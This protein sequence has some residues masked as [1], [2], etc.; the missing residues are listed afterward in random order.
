MFRIFVAGLFAIA[1]VGLTPH[2]HAQNN[3]G[4]EALPPLSEQHLKLARQVFIASKTGRSYD[5][6]LPN[7]AE[8]AKST[9]VR[10][11]PQIQ[12]GVLDAV[13]RVALKM[14]PM[15][16]ELDDGLIRVWARA[17]SEEELTDLL[18]FFESP[19]GQ[20]FS[21]NYSKVIST[22]L[23]LAENWT[24]KIGQ[25]MARRTKRELE[26]MVLQDAQDLRGT[27]TE[28]TGQ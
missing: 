9:F 14:V 21:E 19:T 16:K 27:T 12:L 20:K 10:S 25:V 15:R 1:A 4:Q 7:V 28:S 13:D 18:Q 11:N 17:F 5:D 23:A 2:S 6:I 22:Q 8:Q 26:K 24:T 3:Q